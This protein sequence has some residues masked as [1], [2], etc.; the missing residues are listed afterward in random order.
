MKLIKKIV[1]TVAAFVMMFT[2]TLV[3]DIPQTA[4]EV[5]AESYVMPYK[6]GNTEAY[7]TILKGLKNMDEKISVYKYDLSYDEYAEILEHILMNY[8]EIF[9]VRAET[10]YT[11]YE[12]TGN[13][14]VVYPTYF[15]DEDTVKTRRKQLDAA[16]ND[17]I[18]DIDSSWSEGTLCS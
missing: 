12:K 15:Y 9:Y 5:S 10:E 13:L 18:K 2:G 11:Y 7:K 4:T 3:C 16:V 6:G 8:P 14:V 1:S 17:I